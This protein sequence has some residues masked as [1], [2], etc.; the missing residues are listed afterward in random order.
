MQQ[1]KTLSSQVTEEDQPLTQ[2]NAPVFMHKFVQLSKELQPKGMR[3]SSKAVTP[4][5]YGSAMSSDSS[6]A[7]ILD[8][9]KRK[10]K[11]K[12]VKH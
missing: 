5:D 2:Q 8:D 4:A 11:S 1:T 10:E 12:K 3:E 7:V 9:R 6:P